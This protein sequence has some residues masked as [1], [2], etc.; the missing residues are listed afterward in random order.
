[1]V[2]TAH[3][4]DSGIDVK[5]VSLQSTSAKY[6]ADENKTTPMK[7][8]NMRSPSSRMEALSVCPRI[9]NPF[10]WRDS[11]KIRKTLT[12]LITRRIA[13]DIPLPLSLFFPE[14][15]SVAKLIKYGAIATMSITFIMSFQNFSL[16]G[17]QTNLTNTSI[18]NQHMHT[19]SI[20]QNGFRQSLVFIKCNTLLLFS[21]L[22]IE[23]FPFALWQINWKAGKV[24]RQKETIDRMMTETDRIATTRAEVEL[25]GYLKQI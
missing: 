22:E 6:T 5:S 19:V 25:S 17:L 8:K 12:S 21:W 18:L 9:C 10:E 13:S 23:V 7:R 20:I 15:S 14:D 1:M 3:Q 11:L 2:T 16:L 24:S 4:N